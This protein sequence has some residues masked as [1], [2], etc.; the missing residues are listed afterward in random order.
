[1]FKELLLG[2][3][4]AIGLL[5]KKDKL[6]LGVATFLM[7]ITGIL[8]NGPAIILGKMVDKLIG[9]TTF[10]FNVVI[11]FVLIL[12]GVIM[13]QEVLTV[14]RKFLI[15]NIATQTDKEQTVHVIRQLLKADIGGYLYQQQ[16]GSLYGRIFRSIE[17]LVQIVKLTFRISIILL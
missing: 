3:K 5:R 11:P 17:G 9:G 16:I 12:L 15:E 2:V 4:R 13:T 1:V 10:Q 6:I 8:A 14:I 7:L